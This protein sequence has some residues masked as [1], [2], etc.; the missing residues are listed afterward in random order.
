M[1]QA[2]QVDAVA[3]V[4]STV[5]MNFLNILDVRINSAVALW[6]HKNR[7]SVATIIEDVAAEA[8]PL[9]LVVL[10]SYGRRPAL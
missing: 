2:K 4:C 5:A 8:V 6:L 3:S 10:A 7:S 1:E 9:Q